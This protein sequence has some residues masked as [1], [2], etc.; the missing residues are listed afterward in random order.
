M[1]TCAITGSASG[2]GA[3]IRRRLERD[4]AR[5]I[6]VDLRD[7]EVV[8]DLGT[9][10]GR[11]AAVAG[12]LARCENGLD[13]LVVAAGIGTHV[14]PPSR[15]ASVNYFGAVDLLDGLFEA[16]RQ[17]EAPAALAVSSN[18]AQLAPV[19]ESPYVKAL[20]A[21]DEPEARRIAD[22]VGNSILAYLG[23]KHALSRAV[24]RRAGAW[25]GAGVRINAVAPGPVRTPLLQGDMDDPVTGA[26]VKSFR[27][28]LGRVAEPEEIA[29]LAAFLLGP[30]GSFIQGAIYYI[31]GGSDA[32]LR[33]DRF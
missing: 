22:E 9:A 24:R 18:S 21:H 1:I 10:A 29:E 30:A 32:E 6:G 19:D 5:V 4:G 33:P 8:A 25:A 27:V 15:I 14:R 26:A 7:A 12:V 2:I 16:L 20:L 17:G 23:S 31:D 11:D 13:R 28:P 3:A